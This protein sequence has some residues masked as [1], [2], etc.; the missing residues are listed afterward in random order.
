MTTERELN[1]LTALLT[2]H[3]EALLNLAPPRLLCT[4]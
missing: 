4:T 2:E 3:S 1:E